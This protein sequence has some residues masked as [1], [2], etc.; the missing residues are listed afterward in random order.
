[1]SLETTISSNLDQT[2]RSLAGA[3]QRTENRLRG[4]NIRGARELLK[5]ARRVVHV[6]TGRLRDSLF[7]SGPFDVGSGAF[8]ADVITN[9]SYAPLEIARGGEHDFVTRALTEGQSIID[10]TAAAMEQAIIEEVNR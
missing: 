8:E 1:M 9:V 2:A 7:V 5:V 4:L 6:R 10:D 3:E